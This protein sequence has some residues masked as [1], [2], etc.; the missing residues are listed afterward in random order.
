MENVII[1][2]R[3]KQKQSHRGWRMAKREISMSGVLR[4]GPLFSLKWR[5]LPEYQTR[6]RSN[7]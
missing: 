1:A 6:S 2:W 4:V 3:A 5:S 7:P